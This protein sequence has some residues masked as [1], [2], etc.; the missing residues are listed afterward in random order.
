M[1]VAL[2]LLILFCCCSAYAQKMPSDYFDEASQ[3]YENKDLEKALADFQYI[4]DHHP[5]NELYPRA[6][7]NVGYIY[8]SQKKFKNA[9][10]VFN[11]I[12]N[13]NFDER[14]RVGGD[15]MSNP[16][17]NYRHKASELLSDI[18]YEENMY[19]SALYYFAL[20]DTANPYIHFCGNEY[21]ANNVHTAL[22]YADIYQKLEQPEHA[23][24]KLLA[25]VFI[26]LADNSAVI[27]ELQ[28]LLGNK[29]GIKA[30]LDE[31][32]RN[33][34][35]KKLKS[36]NY[37]YTQ[38]YITFLDAEIPVPESAVKDEEELDKEKAVETIKLTEFYKM[39]EKL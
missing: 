14:E 36:G 24:K 9:I 2:S 35:P 15:I 4:V 13:G 39:V 38:Y 1:K 11:A 5:K 31:S 3:S 10:P 6:F 8:Y 12:V 18:Y 22:R 30:T 7:Y 16:Y 21:A 27:D 28:R 20:A 26:E 33:I 17:A 23:V 25:A 34:Y 19:D 29:Q 32:L 37:S